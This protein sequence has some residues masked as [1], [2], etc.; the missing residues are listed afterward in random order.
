[1]T[2][3]LTGRSHG[4]GKWSGSGGIWKV[5]P[6]GFP[7]RLDTGLRGKEPWRTL[8]VWPGYLEGW[9]CHQLRR[10]GLWVVQFT[11]EGQE[12]NAG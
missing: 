3:A 7:D 12:F 1:M 10:S 4:P 5:E 6:R 11:G 9:S 8:R 2:D